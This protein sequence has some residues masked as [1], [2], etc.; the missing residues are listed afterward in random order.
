MTKLPFICF[1]VLS[2][3]LPSEAQLKAQFDEQTQRIGY[4]D[5][6]RRLKIPYIFKGAM[7]FSEG[8][9]AVFIDSAWGFIDT[10]GRIAIQPVFKSA[11]P[12]YSGRA[13]VGVYR[14][15]EISVIDTMEVDWCK[16]HLSPQWVGAHYEVIGFNENCV[17]CN[18]CYIGVIDNQGEFVI[19]PRYKS[20]VR[21]VG[22]GPPIYKVG[23]GTCTSDFGAECYFELIDE[24]ERLILKCEYKLTDILYY[25]EDFQY[26]E[27]RVGN[28]FQNIP[29]TGII[30]KD[31]R[32][33]V[34]FKYYRVGVGRV[35][36]VDNP[37]VAAKLISMGVEREPKVEYIFINLKDQQVV[38]GVFDY[39]TI[40]VD[41]VA[42]VY[43]KEKPFCIR[44]DG[45]LLDHCDN[46]DCYR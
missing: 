41:G 7:D 44:K 37:I 3:A 33:I 20:V 16:F 1:I 21:M 28:E 46:C 6:H 40:F 38:P 29:L 36:D 34:P 35:I 17:R 15:S 13:V 2:F 14:Q 30:D 23:S 31:C 42:E 25:T 9:A 26:F 19:Q 4:V 27:V 8:L 12:F 5:N 11:E 22:N 24:K 45:V 39:A 10:L 43:K 32:V 18:A